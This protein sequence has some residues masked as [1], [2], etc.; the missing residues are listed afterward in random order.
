[1]IETKVWP[2]GPYKWVYPYSKWNVWRWFGN[3]EGV[4]PTYYPDMPEW[5]RQVWWWLRNPMFNFFRFIVGVEDHVITVTGTA[6][7][8]TA[9][10]MEYDP[11]RSG[12]T[13]SVIRTDGWPPLPYGSYS[14]KYVVFYIGWVPSGGRLSLKT[15]FDFN[16]MYMGLRAAIG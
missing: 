14:S 5:Q 8:F 2:E 16:A 11:P 6:P 15:N 9:T 13:W 12:F 10:T 4:D 1:M 3:V 7:V